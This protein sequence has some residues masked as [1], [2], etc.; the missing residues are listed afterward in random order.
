MKLCFM[1][2]EN[3][4]YKFLRPYKTYS[5]NLVFQYRLIKALQFSYLDSK[6]KITCNHKKTISLFLPK[7]IILNFFYIVKFSYV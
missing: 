3:N 5:D 6:Q 7:E 1:K 2:S 4:G